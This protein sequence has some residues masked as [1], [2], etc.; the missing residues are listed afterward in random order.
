MKNMQ[1]VSFLEVKQK[2]DDLDLPAIDLVIGIAR[3]GIVPASLV[4]Y[5]LGCELEFVRLN[6]RDDD[7][8]PLYAQPIFENNIPINS[9][10]G[11]KILLVD[12]VGVSGK[13]LN[14]AK[15]L[16]EGEDLKTLIFK[17]KN[18]DFILFPNI[19][20]CVNW[21]WKLSNER[22]KVG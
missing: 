20:T 8:N 2:L 1:D 4:A 22:L 12:D 3:G 18:A 10:R 11:K 16:F 19:E 15:Q 14:Q 6:Y 9:Y 21:K 17:G 13:T 7:N 5:K